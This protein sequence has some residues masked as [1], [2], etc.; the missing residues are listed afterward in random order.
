MRQL[1]RTTT[2]GNAP[3]SGS[4]PCPHS[5][6]SPTQPEPTPRQQISLFDDV[7]T[8]S[9]DT[10]HPPRGMALKRVGA[11]RARS[12]P[13][14]SD[15]GPFRLV[16]LV[17]FASSFLPFRLLSFPACF[18]VASFVPPCPR[19]SSRFRLFLLSPYLTCRSLSLSLFSL[20]FLALSL[21]FA[22]FVLPFSSLPSLLFSL[23]LTLPSSLSLCLPVFVPLSLSLSLSLCL[24]LCCALR[25]LAV[26][27]GRCARPP[28]PHRA[29]PR[30]ALRHVRCAAVARSCIALLLVLLWR[31]L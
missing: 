25:A 3:A 2:A 17:L 29:L 18:L 14:L 6:K 24:P 28:R 26:R 27:N 15:C 19:A 13:S 7:I 23:S 16:P 5:A 31:C 10:A 9:T 11:S 12:P 22:R 30:A 8:S 1:A 21:V 4:A 20:S